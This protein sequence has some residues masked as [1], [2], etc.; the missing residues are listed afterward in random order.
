MRT[1]GID[2]SAQPNTTGIAAIEWD[3]QDGRPR[4]EQVLVPERVRAG[5]DE[6]LLKL[7][8]D[9]RYERVGLDAP[10]G[11]PVDFA[12]AVNAW[13]TQRGTSAN[14]S[15][16]KSMYGLT[17]RATDRFVQQTVE[18]R[19]EQRLTPLS[20][21]TDKIAV[22]AMRTM[23]LISQV[24]G[25]PDLS[26][27]EGPWVEVYPSAALALWELP[28][29][30]YKRGDSARARRAEIAEGI[31]TSTSLAAD[32]A[33]LERMLAD[34]HFLDAVVCAL[35]ARAAALNATTLPPPVDVDP[36]RTEGW[37]HLP[38]DGLET[39][40]AGVKPARPGSGAY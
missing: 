3:T 8:T 17:H 11:W 34:D 19:A 1:L 10:F 4:L 18:K 35:V 23:H 27:E 14:E 25:Q 13:S 32:P 26:G 28:H 12:H 21:S 36:A 2:I 30:G 9:G 20:V 37:I 15:A 33:E 6:H 40:I 31:L 39:L 7:L 38:M 5:S 24:D 29:R 22:P 16:R